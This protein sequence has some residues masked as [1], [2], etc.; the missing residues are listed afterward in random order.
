VW[1]TIYFD[2]L[3]HVY[4]VD[5]SQFRQ[6]DGRTDEQNY[7]SNII[8][9]KHTD[10]GLPIISWKL[11]PFW[12]AKVL[13]LWKSRM[14]E[15][16]VPLIPTRLLISGG[17]LTLLGVLDLSRLR[18]PYPPVSG[19]QTMFGYSRTPRT[20]LGEVLFGGC[21]QEV[22]FSATST[23]TCGVPQW[24]LVSCCT[25]PSCLWSFAATA[26]CADDHSHIYM[27]LFADA[28]LKLCQLSSWVM[29]Q[30]TLQNFWC[31]YTAKP[32]RIQNVAV[33]PAAA[34]W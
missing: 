3:N 34:M 15:Y 16:P 1:S 2:I 5:R 7:N 6:T 33:R 12:C 17:F 26:S 27:S 21:T 20:G 10:N 25:L 29:Q 24:P 32:Q 28:R 13:H 23:V 31:S 22:V 18:H 4:G 9:W 30:P 14:H 8:R 19:V 11:R